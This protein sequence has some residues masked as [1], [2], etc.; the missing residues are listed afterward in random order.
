MAVNW[1]RF[2]EGAGEPA[3]EWPLESVLDAVA[4]AGFAAIGLDHYTLRAHGRTAL[5]VARLV[6]ARGLRC[7]DV[8]IVKLGELERADV[9][10]LAEA[11]SAL[12]A[13][14]CIAALYR[15]L[16]HDDTVRDLRAAADVLAPAGIRIAFE[17]TSYGSPTSLSAAA[18]V[19]E[20]VG[21]ERCGLLVDAWHVF[22]GGEA[23][24][25]IAR[26]D[27]GRIALVH[28]SDGG[29]VPR[30]DPVH[31]GRFTRLLP[32]TGS[33]DLD[34]L[35][36]ALAGAGYAG[37]LALEVLSSELRR[38]PPDEGARRLLAAAR[39]ARLC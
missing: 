20:A 8:G 3:P 13:P 7:T 6:Q 28:L 9:E 33:F 27:A 18:S 10:S 23:L 16:S 31:E 39:A 2:P 21:W 11:G 1:V 4:A 14:L 15:P 12:G 36:D 19:C 22:R 5:E 38:L 24:T 32:G 35:A 17:F 30:A 34:G 26:L 25:D 29:S 37:P